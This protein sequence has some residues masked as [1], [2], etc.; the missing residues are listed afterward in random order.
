M[1][2]FKKLFENEKADGL[3]GVIE[4]KTDIMF[5]AKS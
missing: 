5:E 4:N 1:A 3:C 2:G